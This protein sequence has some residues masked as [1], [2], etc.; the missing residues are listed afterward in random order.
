MK[1]ILLLISISLFGCGVSPR[2]EVDQPITTPIV[3][4]NSKTVRYNVLNGLPKYCRAD[5]LIN[6]NYISAG[7]YS[8]DC[9]YNE[10][11][12]ITAFLITYYASLPGIATLRYSIY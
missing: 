12:E 4:T 9:E 7:S 1:A 10:Q 11:N 6:G 8:V 2:G 3:L 5:I